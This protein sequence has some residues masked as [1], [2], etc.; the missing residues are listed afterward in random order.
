MNPLRKIALVAAAIAIAPGVVCCGQPPDFGPNVLV[1]DPAMPEAAM[2]QQ[3]DKVYAIEQHSEFGSARYALLFL[4]GNYKVDVPIGF[5][6]QVM[7]LGASPDAVH[8]AGNVHADASLPRNNATCTFWRGAEGFSVAPE[9]G[10]MQWAVSQAAPFRHMHVE[11]NLVLHQDHGQWR[12][13]V[14]RANRRQ[15]RLRL[16]A[17]MDRT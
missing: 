14:G 17:A 2:Q 13:D 10:T 7:G 11:G 16:A 6:T 9:G 15:R 8:I 3:I 4:P 5:Y 1:F 12:L